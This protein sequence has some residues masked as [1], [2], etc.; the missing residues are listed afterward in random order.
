MLL[1][2]LITQVLQLMT[3][4]DRT[5]RR[6]LNIL[7]SDGRISNT[8]LAERVRRVF[9]SGNW[10]RHVVEHVGSSDRRPNITTRKIVGLDQHRR[11]QC[12]SGLTKQTKIQ[13]TGQVNSHSQW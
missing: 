5:N 1:F 7:Q 11:G 10:Q 2:D 3:K 8:D 13:A 12:R 9:V 4:I 6:I